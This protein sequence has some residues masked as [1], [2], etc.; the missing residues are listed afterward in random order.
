M[1]VCASEAKRIDANEKSFA[2]GER[3]R[4]VNHAQVESF[5]INTGVRLVKM[6]VGGN[7][8]MSQHEKHLCPTR[9]SRCRLKVAEIAL[10]GADSQRIVAGTRLSEHLADGPSL[11]RITHCRPCAMGFKKIQIR[12]FDPG[13]SINFSQQRCLGF[14]A[15]NRDSRSSPVAIHSAAFHDGE[16]SIPIRNG[17]FERLQKKYS[18]TLGPHVSICLGIESPAATASGKHSC[19]CEAQETQRVEV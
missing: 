11:D 3:F 13:T 17:F 5:K 14:T 6:E 15:W 16:H 18:P 4:F 10:D 1:G 9:S 7:H 19:F 8:A 12:C 2:L